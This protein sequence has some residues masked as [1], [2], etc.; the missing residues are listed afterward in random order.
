M[1]TLLKR[2]ASHVTHW[3]PLTAFDAAPAAVWPGDWEETKMES[4]RG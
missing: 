4:E 1:C 3:L 2:P